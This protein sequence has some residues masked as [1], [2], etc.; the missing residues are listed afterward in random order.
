[1]TLRWA[2]AVIIISPVSNRGNRMTAAIAEPRVNR[3]GWWFER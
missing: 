1:L 2:L 3:A